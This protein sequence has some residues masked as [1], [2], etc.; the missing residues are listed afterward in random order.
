MIL[1]NMPVCALLQDMQFHTLESRDGLS[2]SQVNDILKDHNGFM[3]FATQSGLD[4]YD[5]FR[6]KN[7]FF[8]SNDKSS[9]P[10]NFVDG[11]QQDAEDNLWVHT[12]MGYC[13][14]DY[15]TETFDVHIDVWMQKHGMK[16]TNILN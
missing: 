6:F 4:R 13:I 3:W 9:L 12:S 2:N 10:N 5:G 16:N 15:L 7:F 8:D 14:Y 1:Q 11:I